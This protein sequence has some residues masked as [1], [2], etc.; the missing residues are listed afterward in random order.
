MILSEY[1]SEQLKKFRDDAAA[2]LAAYKAQGIALDLT[3][4]KPEKRQLDLTAD[5]LDVL[6]S[7]SDFKSEAGVDCR[8][9]G[10]LDGIPEAK[11]LFSELLGLPGRDRCRHDLA[12]RQSQAA[13]KRF[14][15]CL[16]PEM[17]VRIIQ[18][19]GRRVVHPVMK[20]LDQD[21]VVRGVRDGD[22]H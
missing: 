14:Q 13:E 12:D 15:V 16:S 21:V 6:T 9:Y 17:D 3:R 1:T 7:S 5:M 8:N 10:I 11:R 2:Q 18:Q 20:K 19:A 4:G 22:Q